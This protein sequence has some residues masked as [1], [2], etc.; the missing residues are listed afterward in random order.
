MEVS[1]ALW[2]GDHPICLLQTPEVHPGGIPTPPENPTPIYRL[3]PPNSDPPKPALCLDSKSFDKQATYRFS[4]TFQRVI[5]ISVRRSEPIQSCAVQ[6]GTLDVVGCILEAWLA[7]KG[8]AMGLSSS[9][10][11]MPRE[12]REQRLA[13][14][15]AQAEQRQRD[16]AAQ[17]SRALQRQIVDDDFGHYDRSTPA[18]IDTYIAQVSL[19][20]AQLTSK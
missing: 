4:L 13:R 19:R 9:A 14:R 7:S 18:V 11:G 12:T 1:L 16:Q 2:L 15:Q 10:S 5:N 3:S 8:F 17:L 6:A 20:S